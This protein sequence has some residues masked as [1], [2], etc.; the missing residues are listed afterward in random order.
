MPTSDLIR[1]DIES[2]FVVQ[3]QRATLVVPFQKSDVQGVYFLVVADFH[4]I[5]AQKKNVYTV[6]TPISS[7]S[8]LITGATCFIA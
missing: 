2:N 3:S 1:T 6:T 7:G 4:R 5:L 8:S